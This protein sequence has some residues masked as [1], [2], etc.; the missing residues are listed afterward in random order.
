MRNFIVHT[1]QEIKENEIGRASNLHSKMRNLSGI[2][3]SKS[4]GHPWP[5]SLGFHL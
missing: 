5:L 2:L 3:I 4:E 1:D